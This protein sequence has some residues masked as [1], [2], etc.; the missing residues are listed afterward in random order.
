MSARILVI[1]DSPVNLEL[2]RCLLEAHGYRVCG[3]HD[4]LTGIAAVQEFHPDL[5][6]CDLQMDGMDGFDVVHEIRE[7]LELRELPVIAVTALVMGGIKEKV[8]SSG[9]DWYISKPIDV[10]AFVPEIED[11][12]PKEL[13]SACLV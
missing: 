4:G 11:F 13:R 5:V 2:L 9:F 12:L 8:L 6:L 1:E 10:R 3:A 7:G